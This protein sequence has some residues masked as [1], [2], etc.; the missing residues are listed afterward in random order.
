[1]N[2][3]RSAAG[4]DDPEGARCAGVGSASLS[5]RPAREGD[6]AAWDAYAAEH[7]R[8]TFFHRSGWCRLI[9]ETFPHAPRSLLV[10]GGGSIRGILPLFRCR[11]LRGGATLHSL[12]HTVYGG[13]LA[14]DAAAEAALLEGARRVAAEE[15]AR[16]IEFRNRYATSLGL[17]P[18]EGFVTFEKDLP[19]SPELCY[20][21][22][23][24]KAR[25][26][27]NQARKRHH[28]EASIATDL[29]AFLPLLAASYK[30]LGTPL[31]P[32]AFFAR[33]LAA[34]PRESSI[35][36]VRH[37]GRPV[38]AVLS[39]TFRGIMMP[40]YSGEAALVGHLKANNFK[41]LALM[42][43]AVAI[44]CTRFDFGRSRVSNEGVVR[45][46]INQGFEPIPLPY[47]VDG[48]TGDPGDAVAD[49]NRGFYAQAR[50]AWR[51]LPDGVARWLGPRLV[52]YF[53]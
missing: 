23:P 14:D 1:M 42:E 38:A 8:A 9:E 18:L 33:I 35:L 40:L 25:E 26:A 27:I 39:V 31:F 12:P 34:F 3:P 21:T 52:R 47:E 32:S 22:L 44:G 51:R 10:E 5:V 48:A 15:G 7:P 49:P 43:H 6:A 13:P 37:E 19:K 16:R 20:R 53:P 17:A 24:K 11:G 41:Y 28:L 2:K 30:N 4:L 50:R 29:D 46:K 45:F 36:L